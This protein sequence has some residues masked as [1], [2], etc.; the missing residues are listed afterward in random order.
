MWIYECPTVVNLRGVMRVTRCVIGVVVG[1]LLPAACGRGGDAEG[2][3]ASALREQRI[4]AEPIVLDGSSTVHPIAVAVSDAFQKRDA[5]QVSVSVSGTGGGFKK[6]C[7]G[8][9]AIN[10]ASRPITA[11]EL[12]ACRGAGVRFIELPIAFDGISVVV[13][14]TNSWATSMTVAE[15]KRIWEP[16]AQGTVMRWNQVRPEWPDQPLHLFGAGADSGTYDYFTAAIVGNEHVSRMDFTS[17]EDDDVLVKDVSAD[18]YALGFFGYAY[19]EPNRARLKV[20]AI[21]DEVARNGR[22][23]VL[24]S[25]ETVTAG[26]YQPLARPLF[27]YVSKTA[28]A[29]QEVSD[30]IEYWFE[31]GAEMATGHGYIPLPGQGYELAL[32]RFHSGIVGSLFQ[33]SGSKVGVTAKDLAE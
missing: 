16:G 18:P 29:R 12:A 19:Y 9:T 24:P 28:S 21:D 33:G 2:H 26:R 11:A 8:E 14:P 30:F 23:P 1:V 5:T 15:L 27:L 25:F 3:T 6:F 32:Q 4:D 31:H 7:R 20:V 17:S 10:A 22:G 13:H